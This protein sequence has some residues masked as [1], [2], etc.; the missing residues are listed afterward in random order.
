MIYGVM[1]YVDPVGSVSG[2]LKQINQLKHRN[3]YPVIIM[4]HT[5]HPHLASLLDYNF[6][7]LIK[8]YQKKQ[9]VILDPLKLFKKHKRT[10]ILTII[11]QKK[12]VL[13]EFQLKKVV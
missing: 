2:W 11:I 12:Q 1:M 9:S 5:I 10:Y 3:I 6:Q 7:G 13:S 4:V 8:N